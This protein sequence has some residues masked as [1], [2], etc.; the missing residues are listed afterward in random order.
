MKSRF[1]P[2]VAEE[3]AEF[4]DAPNFVELFDIF[5]YFSKNVI[6]QFYDSAPL[7]KMDIAAQFGEAAGLVSVFMDRSIVFATFSEAAKR[8]LYSDSSNP[9]VIGYTLWVAK[10]TAKDREPISKEELFF[11]IT[12]FLTSDIK[13]LFGT[14]APWEAEAVRKLV[15]SS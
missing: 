14:N 15:Q 13:L 1:L 4:A 3:L 7:D 9:I 2:C 11:V 5:G 12:C 10:N 6:R 8:H